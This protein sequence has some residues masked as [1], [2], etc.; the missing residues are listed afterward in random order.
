MIGKGYTVKVQMMEMSMV[1][2]SYY[3]TKVR[4]RTQSAPNPLIDAVQGNII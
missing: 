3:A 4:I 2:G 1:S